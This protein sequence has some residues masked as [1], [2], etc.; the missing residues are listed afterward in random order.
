MAS[1]NTLICFYPTDNE[2]PASNYATF[3][4]RNGH[5]V[6]DFDTTTQETA[7][8]SGIMPRN[9]AGGNLQVYVHYMMTSATS[10]TCGFD[11]TFERMA[12]GGDDMDADSFATA[13]TITAVTVPGTSGQIDVVNVTCTAGAAGTD[14]I[15]AGDAFRL[16]I[17]RDV[18]NDTAAGDAELVAVEIKEA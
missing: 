2:P 8:F 10:G 17:R 18:T 16:R 9:Y 6:L 3:D 11:V 12:D 4:I 13:Q 15:A 1:G 14:S 7:I 5:P